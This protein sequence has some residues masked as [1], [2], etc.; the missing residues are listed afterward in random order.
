MPS[1]Q[2]CWP[3]GQAEGVLAA[4][5][6]YWQ[7]SIGHVSRIMSQTTPRIV[8][9][10]LPT[11]KKDISDEWQYEGRAESEAGEAGWCWGCRLLRGRATTWG[12]WILGITSSHP[13]SLVAFPRW[14]VCTLCWI[15]GTGECTEMLSSQPWHLPTASTWLEWLF[16]VAETFIHIHYMHIYKVKPTN[17]MEFEFFWRSFAPCPLSAIFHVSNRLIS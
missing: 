6:G 4:W 14:G 11:R 15:W 10:T 12:L 1:C 16:L 9:P 17:L 2:A 13:G 8:T 7:S 3:W 5:R